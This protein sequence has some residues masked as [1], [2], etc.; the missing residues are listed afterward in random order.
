LPVN[1]SNLEGEEGWDIVDEY[2]SYAPQTETPA[3]ENV[4][5]SIFHRKLNIF[6]DLLNGVSFSEDDHNLDSIRNSG[7]DHSGE[8]LTGE[9]Q[10]E[11]Q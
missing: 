5:E 2:Q 4:G 8:N 7:A 1:E 9:N 6:C 3:S 10:G 11:Y